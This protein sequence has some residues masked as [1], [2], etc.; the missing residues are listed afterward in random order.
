MAVR[1]KA[2][3]IRARP[4]TGY[5]GATS[6]IVASISA[7]LA[8]TAATNSR[9]LVPLRFGQ[10]SLQHGL[11]GA[12]TEVGLEDRRQRQPTTGPSSA[13]LISLRRHRRSP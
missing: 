12:L 8:T 3:S 10:M 7:R 1:S 2:R 11:R 6:V 5:W 4:V 9:R 13:L